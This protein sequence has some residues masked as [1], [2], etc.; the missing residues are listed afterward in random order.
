M[1]PRICDVCGE[2]TVAGVQFCTACGAYL[3]W[4]VA[5]QSDAAGPSASAAGAAPGAT[6]P[7]P[8]IAP[9]TAP[10]TAG[11]MPAPAADAAQSRVDVPARA[12]VGTV[13]IEPEL[14]G[15]RCPQCATTNESERRFC[16][17]CGYFI[18]QPTGNRL[19]T[20]AGATARVPWWRRWLPHRSDAE[21]RARKTYRKS[22]PLW[23]RMRRWIIA[24][25]VVVVIGAFL[26]FVGRDPLTWAKQRLYALRGTVVAAGHVTATSDPATADPKGA[27]GARATDNDP[28]TAWTTTFAGSTT[29][30]GEPCAR[31]AD[32][33]ALQLTSATPI[34]VRAINVRAGLP[35][36]LNRQAFWRPTVLDLE[37]G[38]GSC[39]SVN[40][41]DD[42]NWQLVRFHA[43]RTS[44]VRITIAAA[45][46]PSGG[47]TSTQTALTEVQL[48]VRPS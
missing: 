43:V 5:E 35:D 31:T 8:A 24:L 36:N 23:V 1:E 47:S 33:T 2:Q 25:V 32:Q 37:F 6:A 19:P 3:G 15:P 48:M 13:P 38:D 44:T 9:T 20:G 4:N 34:T 14:I 12:E 16:R 46:K 26:H 29:A 10:P 22:L 21:R 7:P 45:D 42:P 39:Q 17:K 40:V 18:G 28:S 30:A 41:R 27:L 11:A